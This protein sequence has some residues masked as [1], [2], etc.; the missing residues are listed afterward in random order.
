ME[1]E[2][3]KCI[4]VK[5]ISALSGFVAQSCGF[6]C[7][8]YCFIGVKIFLC[9]CLFIVFM[10]VSDFFIDFDHLYCNFFTYA[11]MHFKKCQLNKNIFGL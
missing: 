1:A 7:G 9:L 8:S 5:N 10:Q 2:K 6:S 11:F 4:K 3:F